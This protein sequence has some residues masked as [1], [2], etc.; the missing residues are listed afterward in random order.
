MGAGRCRTG[1][2]S[3]VE[4]TIARAETCQRRPPLIA[5]ASLP[6][7]F[8]Q[9][10]ATRTHAARRGRCARS[11]ANAVDRSTA[12]TPAS[13]RRV[14]THL[15]VRPK[16][17]LVRNLN[18]GIGTRKVCIAL[19]AVER[20][21]FCTVATCRAYSSG[22][23]GALDLATQKHHS[24]CLSILGT[25]GL[26]CGLNAGLGVSMIAPTSVHHATS[27]SCSPSRA[28]E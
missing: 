28:R 3:F 4:R 8:A 14:G 18:L 26:A 13:A 25:A 1:K 2:R 12:V 9:I 20:K 27:F 19:R 21:S 16:V 7:V 11:V 5:L 6:K 17:H 22:T 24:N 23:L 15:R 10:L